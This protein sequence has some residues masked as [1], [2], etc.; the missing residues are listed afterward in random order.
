[1]MIVVMETVGKALALR[2]AIWRK[3]E[4]SWA[5]CGLPNI[6]HVDH[7]SDFTSHHL[8]RTAI[9]LHVHIIHRPSAVPRAEE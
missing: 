4:P 8:E 9:E 2:Q 6:L 5:M 7:C 3:N 1:M